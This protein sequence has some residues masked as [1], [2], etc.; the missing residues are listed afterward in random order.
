MTT[1]RRATDAELLALA[2]DA[3]PAPEPPE[4]ID[5]AGQLLDLWHLTRTAQLDLWNLT[6]A[7]DLELTGDQRATIGKAIAGLS[8]ALGAAE[9]WNEWAARRLDLDDPHPD[10]G[11]IVSEK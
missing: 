6:D 7:A 9:D 5:L 8:T 1:D 2:A 10:G 4:C 11:L 3:V